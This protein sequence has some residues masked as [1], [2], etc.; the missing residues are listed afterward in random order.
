MNILVHSFVSNEAMV[1]ILILS[2]YTKCSI[3]TW[4]VVMYVKSRVIIENIYVTFIACSHYNY[5]YN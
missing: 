5:N 1:V 2:R 3:H 4:I